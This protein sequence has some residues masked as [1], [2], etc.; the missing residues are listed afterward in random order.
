MNF[1]AHTVR[2]HIKFQV[3]HLLAEGELT[4][5]IIIM[6]PAMPEQALL[7]IAEEVAC[8]CADDNR[9]ILTLKIAANLTE[10]WSYE[11]QQQ[12]R[13]YGWNDERGNL[14]FYRNLPETAGKCSLVVLC[15]VDRV[16]DAAGLADFYT[17]DPEIIW[18][19]E[20]RQSFKCW[21][22]EK[23]N[24]VGITDYDQEKDLVIFDR[25]LKPIYSCGKGD[26]LQISD[27]LD[28]LDL[29]SVEIISELPQ[30]VL[31]NLESFNLPILARFPLKRKRKALSLYIN[32]SSE[33]YNYTM[34]LEPRQR[35]KALKAVKNVL[36]AV[37]SG[38][39]IDIPLDEEM[40]HDPYES[41]EQFLLGLIKYIEN[42]DQIERDKLLR[43]DFV[44]IWDDILK[45]KVRKPTKKRET[46]KKLTGNPVDVMLTALWLSLQDFLKENRQ[47]LELQIDSIE[48]SAKLFKHDIDSDV[49]IAENSELAKQY[50]TCLL[51]G[52]D[53]FLAKQIDLKNENQTEI[54][55]DSCLLTSE[56]S[57]RYAK[58]AEPLL[59]FQVTILSQ[60]EPFKRKFGWRL[61]E[62]HSFRLA[63]AMLQWAQG[64]MN[65][66]SEMHKL[67]VYHLPYYEELLQT[68]SD[69]ENRRVM[70]LSIRDERGQDILTNLFSP[71]WREIDDPLSGAI[72][73]LAEKYYDFINNAASQ[74]FIATIFENNSSWAKLRT[75]YKD[76]FEKALTFEDISQSSLVGMLLRAFLI[77]KRRPSSQGESWHA[78]HYE[79]TGIATILHPSVVDMF[80]AQMV[81]LTRC[82]NHVANRG[83]QTV[84][85]QGDKAFRLDVWR[86][87]IDLSS[88]K[89]PLTGLL[90]NEQ[91]NLDTNVRGQDLIHMIGSLEAG[92]APLSTRMLL[93]YGNESGED[94]SLSDS[95]LFQRSGE[96]RL[97]LRLFLDYYDL[98]PHAQDGLS[99]AVY[100]NKDV[101]P[102]VAAVHEYLSILAKKPTI[103]QNNKR[104]VINSER[105]RPY[106]ISVTIFTESTE[107]SDVATWV[108][109]WRERW[110]AAET[111]KKYELYRHCRF[112]L[113]HR[114]IEKN[115]LDSFQK[116]I[117]EHFDADIAILYNFIGVG[118]GVNT[119]EKVDVFDIRNRDLK[120][121]ILEKACCSVNTPLEKY[122]RKRIVSNRQF[123]LND[124]HAHLMHCLKTESK[125]SGTI[126]VS[127]GD[128]SPWRGLIDALHKKAEWV[129][130]IDPNMDERLIR[131]AFVE[132]GKKRE[133]IGFGSGV[134]SHGAENFTVSTER[135][136]LN[137][138]SY[139]LQASIKS[140][141]ANNAGWNND[142]VAKVTQG[143]LSIA[144]K[145][146][147]LSLVR[148]TGVGDEYIRDFLAY[149]LS[150]K[151]LR[152]NEAILC[153]T[154]ISL[155]AYRHWFDMSEDRLRPDLMWLQAEIDQNNR[156][157]LQV[158]LIECKM[159][160]SPALVEHARKQINNGIKV[161]ASAFSPLKS[162]EMVVEDEHPDR[163]YWWMQLH[164]L[165]ASKTEVKKNHYLKVL[166]AL[167]YLAEGDFEISWEA[168]VFAFKIDQCN[169]IN[170][171]GFWP[172]RCGEMTVEANIFNI[173]GD[174]IR[175][176][177]TNTD[178]A[179]IDWG[180]LSTQEC[181]VCSE[182]DVEIVED[183]GEENLSLDVDYEDEDQEE[184]ADEADG[185]EAETSDSGSFGLITEEITVSPEEAGKSS[186]KWDA[187]TEEKT[188]VP[189]HVPDEGNTSANEVKVD[190]V[191]E[192]DG[193]ILLGRTTNDQPVFWEFLHPSLVNRHL[194]I[195]GS[196]GQG[197]TYAVQCILC[198]M[199]KFRQN[200]L[201]VD[202]TNGFLPNHL[203]EITK[204][205]LDPQQHVV[206]NE[207]LPINPFLPQKSNSGGISLEET[208]N[209][210][211]KRIAA[212]FDSVYDI[213]SQ[214]YSV[215]HQAIMDGVEKFK[216]DMNL[217][218]MLSTIEMMAEDKKFKTPAQ[219][220]YNKL[221]PFV[222]DRPFA[223][224]REGFDWNSMF[225]KDGPL[226]NIFQLAG[227]DMYSGRLITEFI[228]WDLYGYLQA[229]GQK[230]DP[231]VIVLDEVQ[232]LDHKEGSP[233]SKY[234]REGRK[235]GLSLIL[236][237]Q[238]MSN[239]K[240]DERDRMFQAEHKLFFKPADTELK[241]FANIAAL[242]T[243][244]SVDE[245]VRRLSSLGKGECYS[246]GQALKNDGSKL[247]TQSR[248]IR[249]TALHDREFKN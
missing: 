42:D 110:E 87:Y 229:T 246:V 125:Q 208:A 100:R 27:W 149:T 150:R 147:G 221:R 103:S 65:R 189:D 57:F 35:D 223:S 28:A 180:M 186:T 184:V 3:E 61:P 56:I 5:K 75:A 234:L 97:L 121:P 244:Q 133:I 118:E 140:L 4:H 17:C 93:Q 50:L 117:N 151:M 176:L 12:V 182:E 183:E 58:N 141:F 115:K 44:V 101:Q 6:V 67:P 29:K 94:F 212:L 10:S 178:E 23:L 170:R 167:E 25:I 92:D 99:I 9:L 232:N 70:L 82:F 165:I 81:Y 21:I 131:D 157:H 60:L 138:L 238:T 109:Q 19:S 30:L 173:G 248:K 163:R 90:C 126:V 156:F 47:E 24:Q 46:V 73:S 128:F 154:L 36:N 201:I 158:Q 197:K 166:A 95:E 1:F 13:K 62:H 193:R 15:G 220:L 84:S 205:I 181:D 127:T 203:E 162:G 91:C 145:L 34:F 43:C 80:E 59:E 224:G 153:E 185:V 69:E 31:S 78:D 152:S 177:I 33:F 211:A 8:L 172:I 16:T 98:H 41:G 233:L 111:D 135:F 85:T 155:D 168:S 64:A 38:E 159:G 106:A 2:D 22:S 88:I 247:V 245:W 242:V 243:R 68:V 219:S 76:V 227:M 164:K 45:F 148:A 51:G 104:F 113:S 200:S 11:G 123:V 241:S 49:D 210:V 134:G 204:D 194:L 26:L 249:I 216:G 143:V 236:A 198:E 214:Q 226:C 213:G 129:I 14:T 218:Q 142:V 228:L 105:R 231:K 66:L 40:V 196:S 89:S 74:G 53:T 63:T 174:F 139:R 169:E 107:E 96:S 160:E 207:P 7:A 130:C 108:Q 122:R 190:V 171:V 191:E 18:R 222:L 55:I 37:R 71:G 114:I 20:M 79:K 120:F 206:R 195:F 83:L 230:S 187:I 86:S 144:P 52:I 239:L 132:S 39:T 235:F 215:L 237:T 137:D 72:K 161:L 209:F 146:S 179:S 54:N 175:Q 188:I 199:S 136:S 124:K 225:L 77:V 32:K 116:L 102:V 202:Y 112:S 48:I 119:F 217:D 240:K 192:A